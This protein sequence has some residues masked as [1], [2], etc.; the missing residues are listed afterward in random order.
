MTMES[1]E[2]L[3]IPE[4]LLISDSRRT[5]DTHFFEAA[6]AALKGGVD[7]AMVREKHM[8]S[9]QLLSFSSRLRSLTRQAGARLII[10]S[11]ADVALAV[12]ADG[13]HVAAAD[14]G[15]L[16]A[17]RNWLGKECMSLSASCHNLAELNHAH[18]SGADFA[19]LASV[20]PTASHPDSPCLG[21]EAFKAMA[22]SAPI[23]VLALGGIRPENRNLLADYGVAVIGAILDSPNP[24]GSA[25][26]LSLRS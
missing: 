17:M 26:G 9:A 21:V 12:K 15:E 25:R 7:T 16:P 14:I 3:L 23:P 8:N 4:L 10:H 13:V 11:Q 19:L 24:E 1:I 18:M 20:F 2:S 5:G 6:E 22:G